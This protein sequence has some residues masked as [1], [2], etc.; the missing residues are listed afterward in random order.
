M[1][2]EVCCKGDECDSSNNTGVNDAFV[3]GVIFGRADVSLQQGFIIGTQ[4]RPWA[5]HGLPHEAAIPLH[6]VH[7]GY[8]LVASGEAN[9][10]RCM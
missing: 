1:F 9:S 5:G 3:Q 7:I 10:R 4:R 6:A 2:T 8:L